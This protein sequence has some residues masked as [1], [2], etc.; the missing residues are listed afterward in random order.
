M[1]VVTDFG[2]VVNKWTVIME[3][4]HMTSDLRTIGDAPMMRGTLSVCVALSKRDLCL[5]M[6]DP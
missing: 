3:E 4:K 5:E 1:L 2:T 6:I